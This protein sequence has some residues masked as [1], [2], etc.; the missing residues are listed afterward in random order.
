MGLFVLLIFDIHLAHPSYFFRRQLPPGFIFNIGRC[1]SIIFYGS[2][3]FRVGVVRCN[4]LLPR[5]NDFA[6]LVSLN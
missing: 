3:Y 6:S 5:C 1:H 4:G 2:G